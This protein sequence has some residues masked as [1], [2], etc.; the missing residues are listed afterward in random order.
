MPSKGVIRCKGCSQN[1]L[2]NSWHSHKVNKHNRN[3]PGYTLLSTENNLS[4]FDGGSNR[5][6]TIGEVIKGVVRE[7]HENEK[8]D[9]RQFDP[10]QLEIPQA[11]G[12]P[13]EVDDDD[14]FTDDDSDLDEE[15]KKITTGLSSA[16]IYNDQPRQQQVIVRNFKDT[17]TINNVNSLNKR[18]VEV[19]N[20]FNGH[21]KKIYSEKADKSQINTLQNQINHMNVDIQALRRTLTEQSRMVGNVENVYRHSKRH[22]NKSKTARDVN[23]RINKI[24]KE[25]TGK[26]NTDNVLSNIKETLKVNK[27]SID[28]SYEL[29]KIFVD[30]MERFENKMT[31]LENKVNTID[32]SNNVLIQSSKKHDEDINTLKEKIKHLSEE[33]IIKIVRKILKEEGK[34]M[35]TEDIVNV[36]N[37]EQGGGDPSI[38]SESAGLDGVEPD[39]KISKYFNEEMNELINKMR[40]TKKDELNKTTVKNMK[41]IIEKHSQMGHLHEI[42]KYMENLPKNKSQKNKKKAVMRRHLHTTIKNIEVK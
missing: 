23:N 6:V 4:A 26:D 8:E 19:I 16:N 17:E 24:V 13:V 9:I 25:K 36:I 10:L 15:F 40:L 31:M 35:N 39:K 27:G 33:D 42:K 5:G 18:L 41:K 21:I 28:K 30:K 3:D 34:N 7:G 11:G 14:P 12:I 38:T 20:N 29:I 22:L 32:T 37:E 1:I 2:K